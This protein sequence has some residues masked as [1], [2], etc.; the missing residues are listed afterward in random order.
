M[1]ASDDGLYSR[2]PELE[3]LVKLCRALNREG[4][5]YV[6]IGG[7]AVILHG[8]ARTTKDIDL[9]VDPS[10]AN[11]RALKRALAVLPDNAAALLA[12][13][14]LET[15]PTVRIAD[16]VV[17][18]L[19]RTACGVDYQHALEGGVEDHALEGVSIPLASK[20]LLIQ[21]K[22]TIRPSDAA[23]VAYLQMRIEEGRERGKGKS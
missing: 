21:T 23:D 13:D 20:E 17:V 15:Y 2:A 4:A 12:D 18:D 10:A 5:K 16:E 11:L 6:L 8:F 7:F 3:D 22:D 14:E 1:D 19:L 9:L